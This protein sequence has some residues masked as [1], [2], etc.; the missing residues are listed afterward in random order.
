NAELAC[1]FRQPFRSYLHPQLGEVLIAGDSKRLIKSDPPVHRTL[2]VHDRFC[3]SRRCKS[4]LSTDEHFF[5]EPARVSGGSDYSFE[6]RA[7]QV[8]LPSSAVH[9]GAIHL[10]GAYLF[11]EFVI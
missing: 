1:C 3:A 9:K 2:I 4:A 8:I 7:G 10:I 11:P 6:R 5:I